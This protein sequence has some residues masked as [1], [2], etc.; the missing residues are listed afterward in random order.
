VNPTI[1]QPIFDWID[2]RTGE[3]VDQLINWANRNTGSANIEGINQFGVALGLELT[4]LGATVTQIDLEPGQAIDRFGK[5]ISIPV[6]RA[7]CATKRPHAPRR[8]FLCIHTD[9]VYPKD[10]AFQT[11]TRID[12]NTLQGPGVADA[13]GG[14]VVL[15]TALAALERS[16]LAEKIGWEILFNPD[17]EIGS[18]SS[19]P[20]LKAAAE[21]NQ[22]GLLFEPATADGALIDRRKGSGNFTIILRGRSAHVGR[23]FSNGRNAIVAAAKM[24]LDLHDINLK[25]ETAIVNVAKIDGGGPTNVVP[26]LAIVRVNVRT[27]SMAD[28]LRIAERLTDIIERVQRTG[29]ITAELHG[30]FHSPPKIP[31]A[32]VEL[33]MSLIT[34]CGTDLNIPIIYKSSGGACD[35]N[36][37]LSYGL[38]NIDTLGPCG[39]NLHS[40]REFVLIDS[41]AQRAKLAAMVLLKLATTDRSI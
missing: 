19:A 13:K 36:K 37:L 32:K 16:P 18:Q 29:D 27:T 28:E 25:L 23:D 15:L 3:M 31:D 26:D 38:P 9:T 8:V 5:P 17:E 22:I 1:D 6:G 24:A 10:H 12:A 21:R 11:C 30:A 4:A 14:I 41:L 40:P 20:L 2:S 7:I 39:G 33:L 34:Q 35:G